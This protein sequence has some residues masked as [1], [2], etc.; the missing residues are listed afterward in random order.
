[1]K[2]IKNRAFTLINSL[3]MEPHR[4]GGY[5]CRSYESKISIKRDSLPKGFAGD[6]P[7][8]SAIY[9][10]LEEDQFSSF[11]RIKSDEIWHFYEGSSLRLSIISPSGV[12][13]HRTLGSN[14]EN[15]EEFQI[16]VPAD[17][18]FGAQICDKNSYSFFGCTVSPGFNFDD[19]ELGRRE[20]LLKLFPDHAGIIKSLTCE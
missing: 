6:R 20:N 19:F 7:I 3:K 1:M 14:I 12:L 11:H 18:W 8:S 16:V 4:E 9:F 13:T 10:L 2:S 5:Y 17:S 15:G